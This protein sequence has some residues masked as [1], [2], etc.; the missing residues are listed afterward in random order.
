[1]KSGTVMKNSHKVIVVVAIAFLVVFTYLFLPNLIPVP[2]VKKNSL[3]ALEVEF[4]E[5]G[6]PSGKTWTAT[7]G[8]SSE[9]T[10]NDILTFLEPNGTYTFLISSSDSSF[11]PFPASGHLYIS[12]RSVTQSVSFLKLYNASFF[13]KGLPSGMKWYLNISD[14]QSFYST[15][16]SLAISLPNGTYAYKVSVGSLYYGPLYSQAT[17]SFVIAGAPV[18]PAPE[19][20]PIVIEKLFPV[21]FN[22]IGLKSN[23]TWNINVSGNQIYSSNNS[24]ILFYQENGTFNYTPYALGYIACPSFGNCTVNGSAV[25]RTVSFTELFSVIFVENGL[26]V[27]KYW[28]LELGK[29]ALGSTSSSIRFIV[30]SG[31]YYFTIVS[32][33]GYTASPSNGSINVA[34]HNLKFVIYFTANN[35]GNYTAIFVET[36]LPAGTT[37]SVEFNGTSQSSSTDTIV[38]IAPNGTYVFTVR[39]LG[40]YAPS[41]DSGNITLNGSDQNVAI[42]FTNMDYEVTF[43]ESGLPAGE[44]WSVELNYTSQSSST[45]AITFYVPNGTYYFNVAEVAAYTPS[46]FYGT[47]MVSGSDQFVAINFTNIKYEV[48]F[49]ESGLPAGT[50][51]YVNLNVFDVLYNG[52]LEGYTLEGESNTGT[53]SFNLSNGSYTYNTASI[54]NTYFPSPSYGNV[55]VDGSNQKVAINF[56]TGLSINELSICKFIDRNFKSYELH[57][58]SGDLLTSISIAEFSHTMIYPLIP[59]KVFKISMRETPVAQFLVI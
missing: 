1:M 37:W 8:G 50:V 18:S 7:I 22:E 43:T 36:G 39:D 3:T 46:I 17:G 28:S 49:T 15:T 56:S 19:S 4:V 52:T 58:Y 32:V 34:G 42:E 24:T 53:I 41:P 33:K 40:E 55:T 11:G 13:V 51:W 5:S 26:P 38:F 54:L 35:S 23:A 25:N 57:Y 31:N 2:P 27:G 6:L 29:S 10:S 59:F 48:T 30:P 20:S 16:D 44:S 12:G 47:I 14:P 21:T 45:D 9:T